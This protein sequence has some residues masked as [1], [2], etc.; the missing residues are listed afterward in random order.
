MQRVLTHLVLLFCLIASGCVFGQFQTYKKWSQLPDY[1]SYGHQSQWDYTDWSP[2]II[3][4]DDWLCENG[5]A[6][7]KIRWWG[8]NMA[9]REGT[10]E[11]FNIKIFTDST[12]GPAEPDVLLYDEFFEIS[13][14]TQTL[15]GTD[16]FGDKVFEYEVDLHSRLF[17]Q[18]RDDIYW[19][20]IVAVTPNAAPPTWGWQEAPTENLNNSVVG[21][22]LA[23]SD[24]QFPSVN[25]D[26]WAPEQHDLSFELEV[27]PEPGTMV[28]LLSGLSGLVYFV[29]RRK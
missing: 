26:S 17:E 23:S 19:L 21:T 20:S 10:I 2:P 4:A 9:D 7:N 6:I 22:L 29:R 12:S 13:D 3:R 18:E 25:T 14:V 5:L 16:V 28:L 11:G 15:S 24:P 27:V 8:S 1:E